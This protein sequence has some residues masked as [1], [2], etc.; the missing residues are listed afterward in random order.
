MAR[1]NQQTGL[2][3]LWTNEYTKIKIEDHPLVFLYI[4]YLYT[5]N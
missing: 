4:I 3:L 2:S 5:M 1:K